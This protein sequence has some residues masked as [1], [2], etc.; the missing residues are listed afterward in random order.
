MK[1]SFGVT[2]DGKA[3]SLYTL[4]NTHGVKASVTDFGATLVSLIV[5]DKNGKPLDVVLGYDDVGT[6]EERGT[7]AYFGAIIGRVGNRIKG[8]KF[9]LNGETFTLT[10][11]YN[12]CTLHGGRDQYNIRV[13]DVVE[14]DEKHVSFL[15][16]S[17]DGDQGFP[18]EAKITVTYTL[19]DDNSL[20]IHYH[21][22]V[23]KDTPVAMTH[24]SY[25]N[26][27]GHDSGDVLKHLLWI[28]A[29]TFCE[30][31]DMSIPTGKMVDVTGTPLD[32]TTPKEVGAD[33]FNDCE[34]LKL[35]GGYDH[36]YAIN[37]SG[38]RPVAS[39]CSK[40]SGIT[41]E[42]Q[43]DLPGMQFYSANLTTE[44]GKGGVTYQPHCAI[45]LETQYF[46]DSVN[47]TYFES[48]I[49]KAGK[50]FDSVTA[51]K[52]NTSAGE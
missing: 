18:G 17:P 40:E 8:A 1:T 26:L 52:F 46:P 37:G 16:V 36:N 39:L 24:H 29:D 42:V 50:S 14:A 25:F 44:P 15:L 3:V 4:K 13:W 35:A 33:L 41:M 23:D 30:I 22:T 32:F 31:D 51:Y 49:V 2:K 11:N 27:S 28:N 19:T 9:T 5:P 47:Q 38:F 10:D 6:Y 7:I 34:S 48:P 45:C 43:T 21:G 20:E 12:G